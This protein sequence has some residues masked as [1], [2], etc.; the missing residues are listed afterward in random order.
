MD[1]RQEYQ[2]TMDAQLCEME[3]QIEELMAEASH[4][5]YDEYLTD[6]RNKQEQAK[7]RF[8]DLAQADGDAWEESRIELEKAIGDIQSAL[9]VIT[10]ES[11]EQSR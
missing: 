4:S 10:S 5:D 2:E 9:F 6:I 1:T 11:D 3:G 7:A 8:A